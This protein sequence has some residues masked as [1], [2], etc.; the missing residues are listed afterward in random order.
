MNIFTQLASQLLVNKKTL[1]Q[2][3]KT[4]KFSNEFIDEFRN[5]HI[6]INETII[7]QQVH[8]LCK[9]T[10]EKSFQELCC[11]EH[12]VQ[13]VFH[14]TLLEYLLIRFRLSFDIKLIE[15]SL[16]TEEQSLRILV[17]NIQLKSLNQISRPFRFYVQ[18]RRGDI[19]R[20][21]IRS[22]Q[23]RLRHS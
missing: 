20:T 6:L 7:R 2:L 8:L 4:L 3:L 17:D 15:L 12:G 14:T 9:F 23:S 5:D 19:C 16:D 13:F 10:D 11:Y 18:V 21:E 1:V 22:R